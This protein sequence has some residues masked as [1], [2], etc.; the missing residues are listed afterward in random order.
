MTVPARISGLVP[1]PRRPGAVRVQVGGGGMW[2]VPRDVAERERLA[3]GLLVD[4]AMAARLAEA[5]DA[6]GAYRAALRALERRPF[7]AGELGR[8]L[9]LKGHAPAAAAAAVERLLAQG[10]LDDAAF[11]RSFV[12]TR[13]PRGRGPARLRR[14]LAAMGV[15]APLIDA[16]LAAHW[17][18]GPD[19]ALPAQLARR[20]AA[21]LRGLPRDAQR[22]RL[23]AFLARRGYT[24]PTA[25]RAVREALAS[26]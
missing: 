6:E 11:A 22:R 12:E 23:L 5:A 10:L 21:R 9:R 7:A 26:D 15:A 2:T 24:G 8:R 4:E 3:P 14:D 18:E 13:A 1:D 16:A 19:A 25:A 20:R 17:P